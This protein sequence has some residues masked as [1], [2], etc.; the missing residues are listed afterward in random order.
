MTYLVWQ[1]GI[2]KEDRKGGDRCRKYTVDIIDGK[3][4]RLW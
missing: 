3:V 2:Q 4:G 1:W